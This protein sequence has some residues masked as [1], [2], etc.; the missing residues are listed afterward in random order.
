MT[1]GDNA[2]REDIED[3]LE[4]LENGFRRRWENNPDFRNDLKGKDRNI[5]ID[6]SDTGAWWLRV[7]DGNLEE[8]KEGQPEDADVTIRADAGDFISVF[9]G[10][11]SPLEAYMKQKIKVD[12]GLRDIMLVKSFMGS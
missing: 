9:D 5:L 11:L 3:C 12:A 10:D 6:L 4:R 2:T 8:I 1:T 7:R